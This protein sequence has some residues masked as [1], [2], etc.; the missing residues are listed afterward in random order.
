MLN[1]RESWRFRKKKQKSV[2]CNVHFWGAFVKLRKRLLPSSRLSV[3][4]STRN[5]SA[6][7]RRIF[8][9]FWH[10]SIF[11]RK[12]KLSKKLKFNKIRTRKFCK[13]RILMKFWHLSIFP[14][15]NCPKISSFIK[16]AQENSALDGFSWNFDISLFFSGK[17]LS[18]KFKFR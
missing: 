13:R 18:K 6:P 14:K 5:I 8:M 4:M 15:K 17:K 2:Y 10:L 1:F 3:R 11:S 12:K 16:F 7:T 9:K